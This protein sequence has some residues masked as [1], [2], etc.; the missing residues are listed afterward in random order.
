MK[1]DKTAMAGT[2]E[3]SDVMVTV[4]PGKNGIELTLTSPVIHQYGRAIKQSVMETM[5]QLEVKNAKV[6]VVD[7]GA[8]EC[9]IKA[10]LECAVYRSNDQTEEI[11][12]GK[13]L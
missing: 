3:S 7:H 2:L 5:R 9:T 1:I 13:V 12:W 6:T 8:L 10:R 11:P 4:E